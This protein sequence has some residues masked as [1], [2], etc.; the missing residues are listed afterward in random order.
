[1]MRGWPSWSPS[2]SNTARDTRSMALPA[3]TGT[4][5]LIGRTGHS[6]AADTAGQ[7]RAQAISQAQFIRC[8]RNSSSVFFSLPVFGEGRG[9]VSLDSEIDPTLT[10]PEVG[11]ESVS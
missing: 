2:W 3:V 8:G 9:G 11:E 5:T 4:V 7:A 6:C 10:L 1:M